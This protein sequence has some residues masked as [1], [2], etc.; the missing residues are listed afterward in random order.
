MPPKRACIRLADF[1]SDVP[2]PPTQPIYLLSSD[3]D[4]DFEGANDHLV[5]ADLPKDLSFGVRL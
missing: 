2:P 3:S 4:E 1:D 5:T